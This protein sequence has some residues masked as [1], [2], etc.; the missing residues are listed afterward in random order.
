MSNN[1]TV[2]AGLR[3]DV[4]ILPTPNQDNPMFADD[5]DGYPKDNNNISPRLGFSWAMDDAGRSALRGGFGLFYQRTSYTFLTPMFATQARYSTSFSVS[6]PTN[7]IDSGPRNGQ[8]PTHP[9][10]VNG[11]VVDHAA[12]DA[13]YPPGSR[14][15]NG[16]TVRFDNPDRRNPFSRQYS[17]G[18]E[19]Q[20][21]NSASLSV[22]FIRSEQ[23]A[24]YI[25][26]DLN[27]AL[28]ST[29]LATGRVTRTNPLIGTVG[30]WAAAVTTL[31]NEGYIDYHTVQ[32]SGTK[33]LSNR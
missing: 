31:V 19:R 25:L 32:V 11:P 15:P 21:G 23:R 3:Y 28:R 26:M 24:Q 1:L 4:E 13:L 9:L 18:Y 29:G 2:N 22:D 8:F 17:L 10:L 30:D 7:N 27:P 16:G 20:I 6:F 33:R 14:I 5:P 12:I